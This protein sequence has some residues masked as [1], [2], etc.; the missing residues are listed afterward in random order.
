MVDNKE[1]DS[2]EMRGSD[3]TTCRSNR[4]YFFR[5][6]PSKEKRKKPTTNSREREKAACY[7]LSAA[8][9][10]ERKETQTGEPLGPM[11]L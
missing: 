2:I 1:M 6:F 11:A 3:T 4:A 5:S 9:Q 10:Q 8:T 7:T